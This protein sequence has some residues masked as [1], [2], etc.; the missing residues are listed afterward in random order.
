V[1]F[2]DKMR[3]PLS[4]THSKSSAPAPALAPATIA[5][6]TAS[7]EIIGQLLH[8]DQGD[9][10][11]LLYYSATDDAKLCALAERLVPFLGGRD[12]AL[13]QYISDAES[14]AT[15]VSEKVKAFWD[16]KKEETSTLL[17]VF[18]KAHISRDTLDDQARQQREMY[19]TTVREVWNVRLKSLFQSLTKDMLGPYILGTSTSQV[20]FFALF[21]N[22]RVFIPRR[23]SF[24]WL[25]DK[26]FPA[27][28]RSRVG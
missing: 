10:D 3:S 23:S 11:N 20:T 27:I 24:G 4:H 18:S 22:R 1:E 15:R 16:S 8:S 26:G 17:Q 25:A 19:L 14:G 2:L 7:N 13:A 12:R 6:M 28:W 21:E 9:P 5:F